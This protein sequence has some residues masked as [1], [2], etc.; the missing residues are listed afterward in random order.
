MTRRMPAVAGTACQ[1]IFF[2][3]D[4]YRTIEKAHAG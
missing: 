3:A 4:G 1:N 2:I